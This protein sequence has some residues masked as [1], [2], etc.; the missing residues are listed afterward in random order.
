MTTDSKH[1][2]PITPNLLERQFTADT[3]NMVY[4]GDITYI[5]TREGW[6]YLAV[7]IDLF[8]RAVVGW[9][10]GPRITAGSVS[11]A[12]TMV[13]MAANMHR[14]IIGNCLTTMA[15]EPV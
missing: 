4:A 12:L 5:P 1:D 3:P 14:S 6:L 13:I 8:F 2:K 9:S 15:S 7:V 11:T 10:M